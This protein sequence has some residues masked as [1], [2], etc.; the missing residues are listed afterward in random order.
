MIEAFLNEGN[1]REKWERHVASSKH[2]LGQIKNVPFS[3][4]N[5][6]VKAHFEFALVILDI[7]GEINQVYQVKYGFLPYFMDYLASLYGF[8]KNEL[9]KMI[10]EDVSGFP[11]LARIEM[12]N[13][14]PFKSILKH[15]ITNLSVGFYTI[16]FPSIKGQ[17][18]RFWT[19]RI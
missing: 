15:L 19:T 10:H 6:L 14:G 17:S 5:E 13:I 12:E 11:C 9:G 18:G 8:L 3:F 7:L 1:N 4:G 2:P 16:S